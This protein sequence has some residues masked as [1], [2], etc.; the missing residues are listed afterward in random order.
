MKPSNFSIN[1]YPWLL[2][3]LGLGIQPSWAQGNDLASLSDEFDAP[4]SMTNWS[5]V[6]ES[7]QW[8][9]DQVEQWDIDTSEPS[10]M[11][12]MPYTVVWFNDW[13][14]PLI[15]KQVTG[16]FVVTTDVRA[17]G[18]DG[19]SVP[20]TQFSLAGL[21][22]RAPR[23]ITPATWTTGGENYIF[24]SMGHGNNGGTGFQFEVKNTINS[25]ST[26]ILSNNVADN[27]LLQIA[28]LGDYVIV[29]RK[30]SGQPWAIHNRYNRS[31]MPATLQVGAVAYTNWEKAQ[32]FT[33][34][35]HNA[36]VLNPP[37]PGG[38]T[39]PT[40]AEP[41]NPDVLGSFDYIR[42]FRPTLPANLV[43][44]DLTNEGLVSDAQLLA[45]LADSANVPAAGIPVIPTVSTW[46]ITIT[47]LLLMLMGTM[48]YRK[49][50]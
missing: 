46:G 14:G 40:P 28:R 43:G 4:S 3:V 11:V 32:D 38:V 5:R 25:N 26:L 45:F 17:T 7:E 41:F 19:S 39:D 42:F 34:I 36:N 47:G 24:L 8:F 44:V 21:M 23:N 37:L 9:S 16:D 30:E 35:V 29:L 27:A 48:V 33:P 12:L 10:R 20:Q 1:V 15:Y 49:L 6:H 2:A 31:D 50:S 22:I 18:R 13:R